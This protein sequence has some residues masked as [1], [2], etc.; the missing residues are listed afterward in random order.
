MGPLSI[1]LSSIFLSVFLLS[2]RLCR[3]AFSVVSSL[4]LLAAL[5]Q[6]LGLMWPM[7]VS[8]AMGDMPPLSRQRAL[9]I[10]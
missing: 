1:F 8:L 10:T 9:P 4:V 3:G 5:N 6:S 7:L 2:L